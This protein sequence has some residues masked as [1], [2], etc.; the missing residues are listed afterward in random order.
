M[1]L[2]YDTL[3]NIFK[4]SKKESITTHSAAAL[5]AEDRI[6]KIATLKSF[7]LPYKRTF[8]IRND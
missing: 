6:K 8:K 4:R 1:L 3:M 5:Q 2:P 7:Y